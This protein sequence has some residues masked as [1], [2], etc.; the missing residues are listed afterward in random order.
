MSRRRSRQVALTVTA[1]DEDGLGRGR[2]EIPE[3]GLLREVAVRNA[4]PGE[5]IRGPVR[6]RRRGIWYAD[7]EVI[8]APAP[9]R[10]APPCVNFPTCGGCALQHQR[11]DA[12][13]AGKVA[14]LEGLLDE[15]RVTPRRWRRPV[16]GPRLHYRHKA[17]LGARLVGDDLLVGFRVALSN[18]VVRMSECRT[19]IRPFADALPAL[20]RTLDGLSVRGAVPQVELS[21]GDHSQAFIV[22]HLQP[23]TSGDRQRLVGL[24]ESTGIDVLL[25]P[26]GPDSVTALDPGAGPPPLLRYALPQFGVVLEFEPQAFTQVNLAMNRELVSA[27]VTALE[28]RPGSAV[29]DLFC[30]IGNFSLPLARRGARV[31]GL[32]GTAAAVDRARR[33]ARLNGLADACVFEV[34]DLYDAGAELPQEAQS[35]LL[36]PPRSGAGPNLD[37]WLERSSLERVVYVS[38]NPHSFAADAALFAARGFELDSVGVFDMFPHT[39][40]VETLGVFRR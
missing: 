32:E 27:A 24:A 17:R 31:V 3:Q 12:Q 40:H 16:S 23:L 21:A 8:E 15:R 2:V 10:V 37:R 22:R 38:C 5:R 33:N 25:Q 34:T 7:A 1:L 35:M 6:R 11:Y 36:D 9:E 14:L 39:A 13:L 4:L 29:V 30:G 20:R 18:H 28:L 26:G 19:L